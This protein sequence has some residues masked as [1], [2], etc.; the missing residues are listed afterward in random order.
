MIRSFTVTVFLGRRYVCRA[1]DEENTNPTWNTWM[2]ANNKKRSDSIQYRPQSDD[3][4][5]V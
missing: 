1:G 3:R 2:F 4:H 5:D